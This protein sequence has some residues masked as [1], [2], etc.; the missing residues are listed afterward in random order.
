MFSKTDSEIKI[1]MTVSHAIKHNIKVL[2]LK[3]ISQ[4]PTLLQLLV[5]QRSKEVIYHFIAHLFDSIS[6]WMLTIKRMFYFL[7]T[8]FFCYTF[9]HFVSDCNRREAMDKKNDGKNHF[10]VFSA[11]IHNVTR[12]WIFLK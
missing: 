5:I 3:P 1:L 7:S 6:Y 2:N 11:V 4:L 9:L 10:P 8:A 12:K